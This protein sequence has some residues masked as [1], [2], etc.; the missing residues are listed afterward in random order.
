[1]SKLMDFHLDAELKRQVYDHITAIARDR[2]VEDAM[3]EADTN[4]YNRLMFVL[5]DS[6]KALADMFEV[7]HDKPKVNPAK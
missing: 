7:R 1:V 4:W 6:D 5:Q 3:K 2:L